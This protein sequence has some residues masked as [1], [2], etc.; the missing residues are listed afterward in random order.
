MESVYKFIESELN[1]S[2]IRTLVSDVSWYVN[3]S[4]IYFVVD[5]NVTNVKYAMLKYLLNA[6][7]FVVSSWGQF[8]N[9][10]DVKLSFF[11]IEKEVLHF[12]RA[13]VYL[14]IEK[15]QLLVRIS[16][17]LKFFFWKCS[18]TWPGNVNCF[19]NQFFFHIRKK[20]ITIFIY[21]FNHK[22]WYFCSVFFLFPTPMQTF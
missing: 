2:S 5:I 7:T 9:S 6:L 17:I 4:N 15:T 19:F 20:S 18:S 11:F 21:I 1:I 16:E 3:G 10:F 14:S 12:T 13:T 22:F 8:S